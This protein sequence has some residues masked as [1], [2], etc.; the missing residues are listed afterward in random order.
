M[1]KLFKDLNNIAQYPD[2]N[3]A[4][5]SFHAEPLMFL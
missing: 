2:D 4:I 5:E 1:F 3:Y